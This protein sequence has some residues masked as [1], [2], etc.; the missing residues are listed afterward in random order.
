MLLKARQFKFW[1]IVLAM[2]LGA[3]HAYAYRHAMNPDGISYLDIGEEFW[4]GN[5]SAI[6]GAHWSSLYPVIIGFF[7]KIS[8]PSP[9]WEFAAAHAVNF[10]IYL[11]ALWA[12]NFFLTRIIAEDRR[13]HGLRAY[14]EWMWLGFGHGIFLI[15]SLNFI[16]IAA[17][18]PD[19]LIAGLLYLAAGLLL[20]MREGAR[21]GQYALFGAVLG[22]SYLARAPMFLLSPILIAESVLIAG[23]P[24]KNIVNG[25]IALAA[26]FAVSLPFAG[27]LSLQKGRPT[28]SDSGRL[29]Y[30]WHVNVRIPYIGWTEGPNSPRKIFEDP[31]V[32]EFKEPIQ[33]TYPLWRDP[34]YWNDGAPITFNMRGHAHAVLQGIKEIWFI[35]RRYLFPMVLAFLA[36][37][38]AGKTSLKKFLAPWPI[39]LPAAAGILMYATV[40]TASRYIAPFLTLLWLGLFLGIGRERAEKIRP[41]VLG[42]ALAL[43]FAVIIATNINEL[44][45]VA[46]SM[47]Y[48]EKPE[49]HKEWI[50][51]QTLHE[52]GIGRGSKVGVIG[53]HFGAFAAY[54]AKLAGVK[55]VAEIPQGPLEQFWG[56][57]EETRKAVLEAFRNAGAEMVVAEIMGESIPQTVQDDGWKKIESTNWHYYLLK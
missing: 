26:F 16:T 19:M 46:E 39:L 54:W 35:T 5:W 1:L 38:I 9:Y 55:V 34:S 40:H 13:L 57:D 3:L 32:L 33:G 29:N 28:F 30:V 43:L 21:A 2:L 49:F 18:T 31:P 12:F 52:A 7:L 4:N 53:H 24:R 25:I 37:L 15:T 47:R 8:S 14:P 45:H 22:I 36:L 44:R 27:A 11:F 42:A 23:E 6:V 20:R 17:L 48:G 50:A 41:L 10:L 56:K 51:A